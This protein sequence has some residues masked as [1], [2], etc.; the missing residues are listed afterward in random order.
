MLTKG[1]AIIQGTYI[2]LFIFL[3]LGIVG[4][5]ELGVKTPAIILIV[6]SIVSILTIGKIV[7]WAIHK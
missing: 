2:F 5:I 7:Y 6:Y 4:N 3:S 1:Q